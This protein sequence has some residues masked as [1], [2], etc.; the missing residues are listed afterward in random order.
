MAFKEDWWTD[1]EVQ[2]LIENVMFKTTKVIAE[3]L[4][5]TES[6]TRHKLKFLRQK[7]IIGYTPRENKTV[8]KLESK[9]D[10]P[11]KELLYNMHWIDEKSIKTM[12][13][14]LEFSRKCISDLM[15]SLNIKRRGMSESLNN[16]YKHSTEEERKAIT[17]KANEALRSRGYVPRPHMAG[18][19]NRNWKGGLGTY[20]CCHCGKEFERPP[21]HIHNPDFLVCSDAC[22]CAEMSIRFREYNNSQWRGGRYTHRGNGWEKTKTLIKTR[23]EYKCRICGITEEETLNEHGFSLEVHHK[24]PYRITKDNDPDNLVTVCNKCHRL[25]EDWWF[26]EESVVKKTFGISIRQFYRECM[27]D[28][29]VD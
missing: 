15:D 12:S 2:Y 1:E 27:S 18:E 17:K 20:T 16:R 14:E 22:R 25:F 13:I 6:S 26:N 9:F 3:E 28:N 23:D 21:S 11:I 4:N 10:L 29:E 7:G 24:V 8:F 5:R 19:N